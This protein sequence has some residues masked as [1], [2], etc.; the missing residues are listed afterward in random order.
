M[1][2]IGD[3]KY[4]LRGEMSC[5]NDSGLNNERPGEKNT[6]TFKTTSI[7]KAPCEETT[8]PDNTSSLKAKGWRKVS[9]KA[10]PLL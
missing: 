2:S 3:G 10:S 4:I 7:C 9:L 1:T 8:K 5:K 6:T